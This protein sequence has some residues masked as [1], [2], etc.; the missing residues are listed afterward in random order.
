MN[1]NEIS[2]KIDLAIKSIDERIEQLTNKLSHYSNILKEKNLDN[3]KRSRYELERNNYYILTTNDDIKKSQLFKKRCQYYKEYLFYKEKNDILN[4]K[5]N[6]YNFI[7]TLQDEVIFY[8]DSKER[9]LKQRA[10][11]EKIC[12]REQTSLLKIEEL[13][14]DRNK[15][16]NIFL[17]RE[18]YLDDEYIYT[19]NYLNYDVN[20]VM[21]IT[22]KPK[23]KKKAS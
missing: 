1:Y 11:I 20:E 16:Y 4:I 15:N 12:D 17:N 13:K 21:N 5:R 3:S 8:F 19:L 2:F 14:K 23:N 22:Y 6:E 18:F 9:Q 10:I 7:K